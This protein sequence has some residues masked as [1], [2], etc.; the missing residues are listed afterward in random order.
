V[1]REEL[2][3]VLQ[4]RA[5]GQY[6]DPMTIAG[7]YAE[8]GDTPPAFQWLHKGYEERS[9]G[10]QFLGIAP[11]FD[12]LRSSAQFQ[13]WLGVVGLA[14][15]KLTATKPPKLAVTLQLPSTRAGEIIFCVW[16]R[17]RSDDGQARSTRHKSCRELSN[18]KPS[19]VR[20]LD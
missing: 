14:P 15:I 13:Y 16:H 11:D 19:A 17:L 2:S 6:A 3:R 4:E 1:I 18:F 10:M 20:S 8:L 5:S 9:S 7:Y 12:S